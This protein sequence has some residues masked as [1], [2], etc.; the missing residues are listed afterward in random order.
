MARCD[1][2]GTFGAEG[3]ARD[4]VDDPVYNDSGKEIKYFHKKCI[5]AVLPTHLVCPGCNFRTTWPRGIVKDYMQAIEDRK[6]PDCGCIIVEDYG[7]WCA[8][9]SDFDDLYRVGHSKGRNDIWLEEHGPRQ[10]PDDPDNMLDADSPH[11]HYDY[12][13]DDLNDYEYNQIL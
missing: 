13:T 1:V 7:G 5:G 11:E 9:E 2:C 12:S 6:C 10:D 3:L 4:Y 8:G